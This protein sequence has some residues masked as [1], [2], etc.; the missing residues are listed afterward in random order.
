MKSKTKFD[1]QVIQQF[2]IDHTEKFVVGL[3]AAL[4]LYFAWQSYVTVGSGYPKQPAILKKA[5]DDAQARIAKGPE[6]KTAENE[7]KFPPYAEE[8]D[9]FKTL[10]NP[11][12]YPMPN[13]L[14]WKPILPRRLRDTPEVLLVE[15]LRA[16]PGRGAFNVQNGT[17][18]QRWVVVTGAVPYKKQCD[19]YRS[20][21]EGATEQTE[22]DT[23]TYVGFLV[24]R[25]EITPGSTGEPKWEKR[26][27]LCTLASIAAKF[28]NWTGGGE[29]VVD[30]KFVESGL[31]V[32]LA[33]ACRRGLGRRC[34]QPAAHRGAQSGGPGR[35]PLR[36]DRDGPGARSAGRRHARHAASQ[37]TTYGASRSRRKGRR[38]DAGA[39]DDLAQ[40]NPKPGEAKGK[41]EQAEAKEPEYK[42]VRYFDFDVEPGKQYAYRIFLLLQNPNYK[43]D[44]NVLDEAELAK[45]PILGVNLQTRKNDK[46]GNLISV[47]TNP[48]Y[49][50]WLTPCTSQRVPGDMRTLG[51]PVVA[52]NPR[53][54][55][56]GEVRV[57]RWLKK[58]GLSG[59]FSK[60]GLIRGTVLNFDK[61]QIRTHEGKFKDDLSTNRILVDLDG[62]DPLAP[63]DKGPVRPGLML[64]LDQDGNLEILDEVAQTKE[65]EDATKEPERPSTDRARGRV[66]PPSGGRGAPPG[67]RGP[68]ASDTPGGLD[69]HDAGIGEG[70]RPHR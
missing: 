35:C 3:V 4:F 19:E 48:A 66:A 21:F 28:T 64:V 44:A 32:A 59:S 36:R 7:A 17:V 60:E 12:D 34:G 50:K 13:I 5:T 46:N 49:A 68:R 23:P 45:H 55:I 58:T 54:E 14:N 40:E 20:K 30:L 69:E 70:R 38:P 8:I 2:F 26:L 41:V 51:G 22:K 16:I 56:N 42:L 61:V 6:T 10:L 47:D 9:K 33:A 1:P 37:W 43:L 24:Q 25:A 53:Q 29:E 39:V 62:G 65:W 57:L 52:G 31:N 27:T 11:A 15:N 67:G 18:G 63:R